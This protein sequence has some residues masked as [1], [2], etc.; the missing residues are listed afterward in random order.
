MPEVIE[1]ARR[2][3]GY[4]ANSQAGQG[5]LE[6]LTQLGMLEVPMKDPNS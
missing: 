4:V 5:L 1:K 6:G 3:G 2:E